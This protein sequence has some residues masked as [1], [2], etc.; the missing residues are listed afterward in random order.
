M[1]S[2]K[3]TNCDAYKRSKYEA[4]CYGSCGKRDCRDCCESCGQHTLINMSVVNVTSDMGISQSNP[5]LKMVTKYINEVED[6]DHWR[7]E[8][9]VTIDKWTA[10]GYWGPPTVI[11]YRRGGNITRYRIE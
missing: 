6:S 2:Y 10:P 5:V 9:S 8:C 7:Q 3:C 11:T 1:A 4:G